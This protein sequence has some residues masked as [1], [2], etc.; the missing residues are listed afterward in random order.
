GRRKKPGQKFTAGDISNM[1]SICGGARVGLE[2]IAGRRVG[3]K[4]TGFRA[5]ED[6]KQGAATAPEP[7]PI[8]K[9]D[10]ELLAQTQP[11]RLMKFGLIPEFVGPPPVLGILIDVDETAL[12]AILVRH[13]NAITK[14]YQRLFEFEKVRL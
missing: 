13:K 3:K 1:R 4:A 7:A 12:V 14:Q 10:T 6:E 9:R 2:K 5:G 8:P 11:Q